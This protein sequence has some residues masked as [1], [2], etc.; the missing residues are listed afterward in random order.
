MVEQFVRKPTSLKAWIAMLAAV[1]L[2]AS[3]AGCS[4]GGSGPGDDAA[5]VAEPAAAEPA[6]AEPAAAEPTAA[7]PTA[8][9]KE[10]PVEEEESA[11]SEPTAEIEEPAVERAAADTAAPK[12]AVD[13]EPLLEAKRQ[14]GQAP[15]GLI[16]GLDGA[17]YPAYAEDLILEVKRALK[18]K[19]LYRGIVDGV[20]DESTMAAIARFQQ[21]NELHASGV[22]SPQTRELLTAGTAGVAAEGSPSSG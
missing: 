10:P 22:P 19:K 3:L 16:V 2:A 7:E 20:L 13:M 5:R 4:S 6:A 11:G 18:D 9:G 14:H 21:M 15:A 12:E 8:G 1:C 17:E